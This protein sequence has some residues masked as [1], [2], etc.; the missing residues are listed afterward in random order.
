MINQHLERVSTFAIMLLVNDRFQSIPML[1]YPYALFVCVQPTGHALTQDQRKSRIARLQ[2]QYR[3]SWFVK[4]DTA[5]FHTGL[6]SPSFSLT[7]MT[8]FAEFVFSNALSHSCQNSIRCNGSIT[9]IVYFYI[10]LPANIAII[11]SLILPTYCFSWI[12]VAN[13]LIITQAYIC[14]FDKQ[15]IVSV[16]FNKIA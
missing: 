2:K 16:Y 13:V 1:N 10:S 5:W 11:G 8:S 7:C 9:N 6:G 15:F 3:K 4:N 14:T 12:R